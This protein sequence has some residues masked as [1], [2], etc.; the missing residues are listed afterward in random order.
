M[1][2]PATISPSQ[3]KRL[4]AVKGLGDGAR[5]YANEIVQL[6]LGVDVDS[7]TS[8]EMQWGIDNEPFAIVR[9]EVERFQEVQTKS[10]VYHPE[11]DFISGE[12]DGLVGDDGIIEIKCPN[13]TNH[14][15]NL[16]NGFQKDYYKYQ[17]QGYLWLLDRQWCD[18]ISFD[19]RYP[20][21][22]QI[23]IHHVERDQSIIDLLEVR[24]LQF[25]NEMVLPLL[26]EVKTK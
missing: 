22:L 11:Y 19:P 5:T 12:P 14:L 26:E 1:S 18:F 6:L 10:R 23:S 3:F 8:K 16:Q 2:R 15:K 20:R 13:S 21:E 7:Y 24:C 25:W 17:I 4:M 9:Y